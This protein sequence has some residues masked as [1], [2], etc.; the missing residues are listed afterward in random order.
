[1]T[2][3]S[4]ST[5]PITTDFLIIG[6]GVAGLRAA[7]EAS[8]Y[9]EVIVLNKGWGNESN[10][11][12]A[13]GGIAAAL[14]EEGEEIQSHIEDTIDAGKGLCRPEAVRILVEEGPQRIH[15]LIAWGAEFDKVGDR[16]A[17]AR[18][19]AHRQSRIL[20]AKGDATGNE[21]VRALVEEAKKRPNISVRNGHFTLDLFITTKGRKRICGGAW[22][23]DERAAEPVLFKSRAVILATGGAGQVYRRTT[24]PPVATGDGL[25]MALRAGVSLEDMEFF[26]FH[27]TALSLPSAPCFLLSEAMRGEG[28]VLR[29]ADG[30]PFMDRYHPDKELAPRDVVT[31]AIWDEMQ[32]G[33]IQNVFLDLTHLKASFIKERFPMIYA[34][35]LQYGID[36]TRDRIPVAPSAHYLMGGIK[37]GLSGETSLPGLWAVGEVACT[38]VHG[39]NRLA[40]NSLLEG[41]VF[42]MRVGQAVAQTAPSAGER[43]EIPP[44]RFKPASD[45][46]YLLVQKELRETMWNHV[47]I[48]RSESSLL[49]AI[50]RWK[51]WDWV[52]RKPA[53]SRLAL[54]TRNMLIASAAMMEAALRRKESI[55]AHYREDFP[56]PDEGSSRGHVLLTRASLRKRF[57]EIE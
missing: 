30:K 31:R 40:S 57:S 29:D 34:T 25:A 28:A 4:K 7:I 27:P 23:L 20:R 36:I 48:I 16:Y 50:E 49:E 47:G 55:G 53:L 44:K 6:S 52:L 54:E 38:G 24:N 19:G 45:D 15:E 3:R 10:S 33:K 41:L 2:G 14:S 13:Q 46:R 5:S 51:R 43:P 32:H 21:I 12:F 9:G 1:M 39:A 42:G 35:C 56:L 17:F 22:V 11:A 37:T 8:R 26:Q 18:E